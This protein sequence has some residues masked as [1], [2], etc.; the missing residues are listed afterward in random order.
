MLEVLVPDSTPTRS[1]VKENEILRL[2]RAKN[3]YNEETLSRAA[4][5]ELRFLLSLSSEFWGI[6]IQKIYGE[7][8]FD[9]HVTIGLTN[10]FCSFSTSYIVV[11][12][13]DKKLANSIR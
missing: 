5:E 13:R 12:R 3:R 8:G 2:Q 11:V 4:M 1:S 7:F 9:C 6:T 10:P